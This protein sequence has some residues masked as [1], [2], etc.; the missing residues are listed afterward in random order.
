MG[1]VG[2]SERTAGVVRK[3]CADCGSLCLDTEHRCWAC[4]STRFALP[5]TVVGDRTMSLG[6]A[7][8]QTLSWMK[9]PRPQTGLF[10]LGA[11]S[12]FALFLGSVGFWIGRASA[13]ET[14]PPPTV[15]PPAAFQ[16]VVLPA[17]PTPLQ[18]SQQPAPAPG[19]S[20]TVVPQPPPTTDP[21]V[22]VRSAPHKRPR[23]TAAQP[24]PSTFEPQMPIL[25]PA[26]QPASGP[27]SAQR[28]PVIVTQRAPLAAVP[29]PVPLTINPS[30][31]RAVVQVTNQD[32][33]LVEVSL[34]GTE[35]R[36]LIGAGDSFPL[37]LK[38]GTYSL[39][40]TSRSAA[41]GQSTLDLSPNRTY[42]LTIRRKQDGGKDTLALE[43][44]E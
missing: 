42:S 1:Q 8:E 38:P 10:Y 6:D 19:P 40:A 43:T 5:G 7:H 27:A 22:T 26:P 18:V 28:P 30:P 25:Q 2:N 12:L 11:A 36:V 4:G 15:K 14:A 3:S 32:A 9:V 24:A 29:A 13:P 16:P 44:G 23:R 39:Q 31:S 21:S 17:P 33:H 20:F 37:S 41:P 35:T 34:L